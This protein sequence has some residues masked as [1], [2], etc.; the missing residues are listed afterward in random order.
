MNIDTAFILCAGFGK[1]LKPLTTK[2]PKPL[3]KINNLTLLE[4]TIILIKNLDIKKIKLNTFYLNEQI[5]SYIKKNNFGI[6][7]EI[8]DDGDKILDTGGGIFNM[9][10]SVPK[11]ESN[12]LVFNPDTL[13]NIDYIKTINEMKNFYFSKKIENILMVV[14]KKLSFD[15]NLE[16]DFTLLNNNLVKKDFNN[17]IYTGCQIISKNVFKLNWN[18]PRKNFSILD[19]WN[20][21]IDENNLFGYESKNNFNHVT[22][23]DIYQKLLKNQ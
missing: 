1:R 14:D 23:L 11:S 22:N 9:I 4:N 7:I 2:I 12:F 10:K 21:A 13:W 19:L 16:G 5:K 17:Y 20:L 15:Q 6:D 18:N 8:I 3:L